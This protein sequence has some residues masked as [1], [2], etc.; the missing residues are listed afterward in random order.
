MVKPIHVDGEQTTKIMIYALSTCGWCKKVK[1]FLNE[2]GVAYDYI[3]VDTL[4]GE[5]QTQIM[6]VVA[7]W[8]PS[9]SFPTIVVNDEE[10]IV[11]FQQDKLKKVVG[12]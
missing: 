12:K 4:E 3:D 9:R 10:S 8:N 7:K 2:F 6:N 1:A 11:G 5:D